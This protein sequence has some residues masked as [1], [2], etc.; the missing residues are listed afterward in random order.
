MGRLRLWRWIILYRYK[1]GGLD[2]D[3]PAL[4]SACRTALDVVMGAFRT[5]DQFVRRFDS[6]LW[7]TQCFNELWKWLTLPVVLPCL[8]YWTIDFRERLLDGDSAES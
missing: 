2:V 4:A 5:T 7:K 3:A 1:T 8:V 6:K